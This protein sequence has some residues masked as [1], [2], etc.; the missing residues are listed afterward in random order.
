[1]E[2][3][4]RELLSSSGVRP[5]VLVLYEHTDSTNERARRFKRD[6]PNE[7]IIYLDGAA[8]TALFVA[9]TQSAGR[10]RLARVFESP[11]G[12]GLYMSLRVR[13]A[14]PLSELNYVTPY[15]AVCAAR[16][17]E[18][19]CTAQIKI[20]W[21]NDLYLGGKKLAGILTETVAEECTEHSSTLVIGIGIN[22]KRGAL[23][24][25]V[26]EIATS[27]EACGFDIDRARL[28]AAV[29]SELLFGI[30][31]PDLQELLS[32]YR[33]RSNLIG[34]SVTVSTLSE[35]Y[36]AEVMG[37]GDSFELIVN[38]AGREEH[39]ISADVTRIR[40]GSQPK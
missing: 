6:E 25:E 29:T 34:S 33:E 24:P 15:A 9:D 11:R 4:K 37:I 16:A 18:S 21:V 38:R 10:G 20:K 39:L 8:D 13:I 30:G 12:A 7:K 35:S 36:T 17:I 31:E 40:R 32:E 23:S 3:I 19:L 2:N 5:S 26:S 27:L 1:M 28:A 14:K 22:L